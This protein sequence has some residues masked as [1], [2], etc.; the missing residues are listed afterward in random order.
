VTQSSVGVHIPMPALAGEPA[1][2]K[3]LFAPT[4]TFAP[5]H[6]GPSPQAVREM[7]KVIGVKD[8]TI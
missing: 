3:D 2:G 1:T 4:D 8:W 5:R 7:C 6:L